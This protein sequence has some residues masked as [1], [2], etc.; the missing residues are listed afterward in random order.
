MGC[1]VHEEIQKVALKGNLFFYN[2]T[3]NFNEQEHKNGR[4]MQYLRLKHNMANAGIRSNFEL[5]TPR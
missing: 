1:A 3:V 2:Q 5:E 4:R